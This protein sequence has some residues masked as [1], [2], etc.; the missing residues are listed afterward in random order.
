L[1]GV[2]ISFKIAGVLQ[3]SEGYKQFGSKTLFDDVVFAINEGE[4]VGVIGP[5]G[6]GKTT[7]FKILVGQE[8]LDAGRIIKTQ[9]LRIGY[10]E[11]ESEWS[12]DQT[13][14]EYLEENCVTPIWTLKSLGT[15]LGLEEAHFAKPLRELSG[16]YRMRMKLLYLIGQ[17]PHLMLLD[18][19]TNFL[20]LESI[21]ALE[22]FLQ[23]YRG[24]FL[25][26]SHDRE[27][28]KRTTESTLEVEGG[29][30]TK[31]PGTIDDYFEQ[32]EQMQTILLAQAANNAIKRK[33]VQDFV[34]R[35]KAKAS[36]ARQ[37]QSRMKQLE[38][39]EKIEIKPLQ[40]RARI[41]I[42]Q[43]SHTGKE[44]LLLE[45]ASLGYPERT[46]LQKVNLRLE[47]GDRI[48][49]VGFNGAGK[50]TLLKSL[51][52]R[53]P[54]KGGTL[55]LGY[56]VSHSYFAQHLA[57]ELDLN[58][59]ILQALENAAH[60]DCLQRDILGL[61]GSLLFSGGDIQ[62]PI[63]VLS[64]GEKAR[65][66]LGQILLKKNPFL[67]MDEPTNHLDFDTVEALTNALAHFSGTLIVVS[68]DRSF[69]RRVSSKIL[70]IRDGHAEIYP[71]SYDEY[72]WSLEKGVYNQER[73]A[74][75]SGETAASGP[76]QK[77]QEEP[78]QNAGKQ[79][80]VLQSQFRELEKKIA[81]CEALITK[82]STE[83]D[84]CTEQLLT[85]KGPQAQDLA[86]QLADKSKEIETAEENLMQ[87]MVALDENEKTQQ[88]LRG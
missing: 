62:K 55:K 24:A 51:A 87:M 1:S 29:Q 76:K 12:L 64:G 60:P 74:K 21:L 52:E 46:I 10:L 18:E 16:G 63:K 39:M 4:H 22:S 8:S 69:I 80:K 88:A 31:Y 14:E 57:D 56:Q 9:G 30:I 17:E 34:D 44:T 85:A 6:A 40:T 11:Q 2:L 33:Q 7:L 41:Q 5:N 15:G 78:K 43:P 61:A 59:T 37:A 20:D 35:F 38:K 82:L 36:K 65:V 68:H 47:R 70:E 54:L 23:D 3:V 73:V 48:G 32:K 67:I 66:A 58:H 45:N 42:P 81:K 86:K 13:S 26:I 77:R 25:L 50:S 79:S 71:G 75:S 28:L 27:F 83:R 53:L 49:V 84:L 19:P 72:V